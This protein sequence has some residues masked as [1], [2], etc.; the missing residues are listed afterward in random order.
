MRIWSLHPQ[1][2]DPKGLV[3][4]WRETL[5]AKAVLLGQTQGYRH[6]PQL[7][8]FQAHD[9]PEIAINVYLQ[10][11]LD[12][13]QKRGYRFDAHKVGK[14]LQVLPITVSD[15]QLRYEWQHLLKKLATR[16]PPMFA[17]FRTIKMPESH[18][19]FVIQKGAI[20]SW[21]RV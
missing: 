4:L 12:E 18:P 21:E 1:Y 17:Q 5:L 13:A 15:G 11:V 16:H 10:A 14:T 7:A 20:A 9:Q 3:A 19:L 6:H 2:L 8:R